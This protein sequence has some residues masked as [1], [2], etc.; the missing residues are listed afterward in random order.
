MTF[1]GNFEAAAGPD[2]DDGPDFNMYCGSLSECLGSTANIG[3]RAGGGLGEALAQLT[4]DD[5]LFNTRTVFGFGFFL[6]VNIILLNIFFGIIIDA[7]AD[8]RALVAEQAAEV[9]GKCFIC[10]LSKYTFDIE[11]IPW[12]LHVYCQHNVHAYLAFILYV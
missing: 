11:N 8:K 4:I 3:L 12:K 6:I 7:F 10:G 1:N 5:P 9:E 2:D